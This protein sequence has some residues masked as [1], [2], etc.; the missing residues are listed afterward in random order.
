MNLQQ[1]EPPGIMEKPAAQEVQDLMTGRWVADMIGVAAKL[2][3]ADFING[4]AKT[5]E[6]IA[7]AKGLHVISLY[8]LLR[9][10]APAG[11]Q[12]TRLVP[13]PSFVHMMEAVP[14]DAN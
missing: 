12:L 3:L 7:K 5:A 8:Q 6:E 14:I 11:F 9:G 1:Y 2:E 10:L 13:T 4:G